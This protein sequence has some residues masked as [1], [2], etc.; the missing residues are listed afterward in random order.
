MAWG[1]CCHLPYYQNMSKTIHNHHG[2]NSQQDLHDKRPLV[3]PKLPNDKVAA[4]LLLLTIK[5][6]IN[7]TLARP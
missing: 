1:N 4:Y 3:L 7:V 5:A 6:Y 2:V